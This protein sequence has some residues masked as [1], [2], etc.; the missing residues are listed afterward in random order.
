MTVRSLFLAAALF[1]SV[2]CAVSPYSG[3]HL[4]GT[5]T[6]PFD[7]F[8]HASSASILIEAYNWNT[9]SFEHVITTVADATTILNEGAFCPNSPA[10]YRYK[11]NVSLNSNYW[12]LS[13][14]R[15][16][17]RVRASQVKGSNRQAILFT[18]N[19][20]SGQCMAN[21]TKGTSCD[22]YAVAYNTCGFK[23]TEATITR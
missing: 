13:G 3:Q 18:D 10:L 17:A 14:T 16:M 5:T 22:F 12:K 7:G 23:L 19:P 11:A 21:N 15:R 4:S 9:S 2:G 6:I 8:A 1:L 20:N